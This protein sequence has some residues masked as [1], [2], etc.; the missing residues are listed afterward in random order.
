MKLNL[1]NVKLLIS[2]AKTSDFPNID[3]PEIAFSGRSNAGKSSMINKLINRHGF[4]RTSSVPGKTAT[5]NF[6]CID[7]KLMLVDLPGYGYAKR[8]KTTR[9]DWGSV[10][11]K[12]YEAREQ[13]ALVIQLVDIRIGA[14]ESDRAM[15]EWLTYNNIP[16]IVA[17][18]K[19]DKLSKP[20]IAQA[21]MDIAKQ[22]PDVKVIPFSSLD[23][24]GRDN[25]WNLIAEFTAQDDEPTGKE[26]D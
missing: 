1:N 15:I 26:T 8:D 16:V 12:Y 13:L 3:I 6:Y 20:K 11:E 17:A 19:S 22:V 10:I 24:T 18:V 14:T 2:A 23:G 25:I 21:V 5:A 4:A 7:K 9:S